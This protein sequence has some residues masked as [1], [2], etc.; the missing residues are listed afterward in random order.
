M[1]SLSWRLRLPYTFSGLEMRGLDSLLAKDPSGVCISGF[2]YS[3]F[4]FSSS[5]LI[6]RGA[7]KVRG[8][9]WMK[10][11]SPHSGS[12]FSRF[13]SHPARN[14]DA[15]SSELK[16]WSRNE[17]HNFLPDHWKSAPTHVSCFS[18]CPQRSCY[19]YG[20]HSVEKSIR[21][22]RENWHSLK[23]LSIKDHYKHK[24]N[25]D[26]ISCSQGFNCQN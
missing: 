7:I 3:A 11:S 10:G 15:L 18:P 4:T 26:C 24:E 12:P 19:N 22:P 9:I 14:M 13:H 23:S 20:V 16:S 25:N 21:L 1:Y 6:Q 5:W 2:L 8:G 17:S